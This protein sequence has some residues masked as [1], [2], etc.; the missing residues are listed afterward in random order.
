MNAFLTGS[1][2]YGTPRPDS[3]IDLCVLMDNSQDMELLYQHSA[4]RGSTGDGLEFG[5]LNIIAHTQKWVFEAW[6]DATAELAARK[7]VT[8]H[9]AITCIKSHMAKQGSHIATKKLVTK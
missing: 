6:R 1:H 5:K 4:D 3:D 2:A 9:E 7:P 8:R